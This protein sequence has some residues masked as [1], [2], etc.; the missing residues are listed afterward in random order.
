MAKKNNLINKINMSGDNNFETAVNTVN[1]SIGLVSLLLNL[2]AKVITWI[3]EFFLGLMGKTGKTIAKT[4]KGDGAMATW[5]SICSDEAVRVASKDIYKAKDRIIGK[6]NKAA[7]KTS[8]LNKA[9]D[10]L[11]SDER[12]QLK[13]AIKVARA[14]KIITGK[15]IEIFLK[16]HD[17]EELVLHISALTPTA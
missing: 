17:L 6:A 7:T 13:T 12:K 8:R 1:G 3:L 11:P 10:K 5:N 9:L 15:E 14:A 16:D 2:A 4:A